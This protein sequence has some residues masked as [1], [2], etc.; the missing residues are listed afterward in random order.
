MTITGTPKAIV[1]NG[2]VVNKDVKVKY[3][4]KLVDSFNILSGSLDDLCT[5]YETIKQLY[6]NIILRDKKKYI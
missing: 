5:T 2:V 1:K 6:L 4:I 3:Q